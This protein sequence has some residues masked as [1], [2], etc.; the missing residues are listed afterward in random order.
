[1]FDTKFIDDLVKRISNAMPPGVKTFKKDAEHNIRG[2]LE[3]VFSKLDLIT[4]KEF[5]V[6]K[7]VLAKTRSKVEVLEKHVA[8]LEAKFKAPKKK[9]HKS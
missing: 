2:V 7:G 8:Q 9:S 5:E 6:Q 1:M 4:R 3:S